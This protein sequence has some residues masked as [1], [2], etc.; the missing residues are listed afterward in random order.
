MPSLH[1]AIAPVGSLSS[2]LPEPPVAFDALLVLVGRTRSVGGAAAGA[3]AGAAGGRAAGV[4]G[5]GA[6]AGAGMVVAA[7]APAAATP[8]C[9]EHAPRPPF[10]IVP[11]VQVTIALVLAAFALALAAF[12]AAAVAFLSTPP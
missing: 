12:F 9:F 1:L 3:A 5:G 7:A 11:S 2:G 4:A 8:P 6:G 10:D